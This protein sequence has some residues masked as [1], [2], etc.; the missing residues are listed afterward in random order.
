MWMAAI[1]LTIA[2]SEAAFTSSSAS[3]PSTF[4][5]FRITS[6]IAQTTRLFST[7]ADASEAALQRT[8]AHLEKLKQRQSTVTVSDDNPPD[9]LGVERETLYREYLELPSNELK[10]ILKERKL[11]RTGN[12]PV[13]ARRLVD[14]DLQITDQEVG[15]FG[16]TLG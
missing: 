10:R 12:K 7:G 5:H 3:P 13:L 2:S 6:P 1:V 11:V 15:L 9:P 14:D 8:A 16:Q 4:A